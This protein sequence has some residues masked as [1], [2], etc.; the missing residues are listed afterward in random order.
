MWDDDVMDK[1]RP[2]KEG[3]SGVR[4]LFALLRCVCQTAEI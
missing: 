4:L 3:V 1:N 2:K